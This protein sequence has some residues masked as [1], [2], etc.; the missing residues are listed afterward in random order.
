MTADP[1]PPSTVPLVP[2]EVLFG[3]PEKVQPRISP[4]GK[5]LAYI[6]PVNGVLNVWVGEVGAG[7]DG[8]QPVTND[9]DRG[10]RAYF[11]GQDNARILY[12][13]DAGGDENW[14]LYDTEL[15]TGVT[16]DLTPFEGVQAQLIAEEKAYPT[17]LLVG[18]NKDNPQLHDV[19]HLDLETGELELVLKNPGLVGFVADPEMRVRAGLQPRPDGGMNL[20]GRRPGAT[21]EEWEV[22]LEVD[23]D[24]ALGTAPIGFTA[25]GNGLYLLSSV[26]ANAS[27]LLHLDLSR[28]VEE[29]PGAVSWKATILAQDPQYDVSGVMSNPDTK[30]IQMVS[31]TKARTEHVVLD[32]SIAK[33]MEAISAVQPGDVTFLG[34]DHADR[35]WL[36]A[37]TVDDGPVAYYAWDRESQ[38]ATFLFH[39]QPALSQYTLAPMEPF[40][41]TARDGLEIHGYLTFPPGVERRDL[42]AVL[43]VHGGPWARDSWGFNAE[44]Q[45]LANRGY[46]SVQVNFRGST[47]YGKDF[48]NKGNKQ[49]AAAMHDDLI[50]AVEHVVGH[51]WVDRSKVAISGGSYG[52]YAALVGAT[53]TPDVFCCAVDVVGPSNLKTLIES[54]PP[55]WA[56][57]VAQFHE[58]VGNPETEEALLWERSPLSR[59]DQIKIPILVAQGANDPRVKQAESEQIVNAMKEKGID[60]VYLLFGDEGHGFA[61]PENRMKFF[62]VAEKFLAKHLGGRF[63]A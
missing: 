56:P 19:Y 51:G 26:D 14:R 43:M 59:V 4:D 39:H 34:R 55:Y 29:Q 6:A 7:E 61:K 40:S 50:D 44:A 5:R 24:D 48:V 21:A 11:W 18:L 3:N 58:R 54:I 8:F 37:F 53:F 1:T 25:D 42:P 15:A 12:V 16:R 35:T 2:R 13:Q 49:W 30:E 36:V 46:V 27:R 17:E 20:V 31:F 52:G 38:A 10:I 60:H 63:E 47:G 33:D 28:T 32:P 41:F 9:T 45:W 62:A 22:F 23:A 57:I